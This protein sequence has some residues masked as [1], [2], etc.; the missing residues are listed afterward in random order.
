M[1]KTYNR[2]ALIASHYLRCIATG[3]RIRYSI[4]MNKKRA[5]FNLI[6]LLVVIAIV[7]ILIA[8][9][10]PAISSAR[11]SSRIAACGNNLSQIGRGIVMYAEENKDYLPSVYS[12]AGTSW[13]K[14]VLP[15]LNGD[16]Q[17]FHCTSDADYDSS[18]PDHPRTYAANGSTGAS[19]ETF[20]FGKKNDIAGLR[21]A[22]LDNR[23]GLT[24]DIILVGERPDDGAGNR[25]YM[26]SDTCV[27]LDKTPGTL[28]RSG[29]GANYLFSAM[30]V[31]YIEAANMPTVSTET[32]F[33]TIP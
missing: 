9:L 30:S 31:K 4:V 26:G 29:R 32:N 18:N 27:G 15:Y 17:V 2:Q 14:A 23:G 1:G 6:E 16:D 21:I 28:H 12:T 13:D 8:L 19:T 7:G 20:P 5:G 10:L 25:G 11:E 24:M 33:W 22:D 3:K